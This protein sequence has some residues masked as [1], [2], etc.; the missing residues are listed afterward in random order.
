MLHLVLAEPGGPVFRQAV[1]S[2]LAGDRLVL[3]GD[4]VMAVSQPERSGALIELPG[5]MVGVSKRD[6]EDRGLHDRLVADE[7]QLLTDAELVDWLTADCGVR[8]WL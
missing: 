7:A 8:S 2:L 3:A 1:A 5:V 4:A 6:L